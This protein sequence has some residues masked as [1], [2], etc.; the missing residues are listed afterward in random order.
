MG[1]DEALSRKAWLMPFLLAI[2]QGTEARAGPLARALGVSARL[3]KTALWELARLGALEGGR[4]KP[5][6][7]EWL[8]RQSVAVRGRR[9]LW[10]RGGTCVLVVARRR[11]VSVFLIPAEL[12][13]KAEELLKAKGELSAAEAASALGCKPIVASRALQALLALGKATREGRVYR[14]SAGPRA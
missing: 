1:V 13:E 6:F 10:R 7:T 12:V 9:L 5:E 8:S 3:A 2:Q 14:H 4:L 11:R